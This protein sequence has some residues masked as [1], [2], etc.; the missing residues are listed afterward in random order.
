MLLST[1]FYYATYE[2]I[3]VLVW[4]KMLCSENMVLCLFAKSCKDS[5]IALADKLHIRS[6][7]VLNA[8][9][10]TIEIGS[11]FISLT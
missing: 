6:D 11:G 2:K 10:F 9:M 7:D 4:K 5:F 1:G 3:A 8:S